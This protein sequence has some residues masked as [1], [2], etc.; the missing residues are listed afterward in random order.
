MSRQHP[1]FISAAS[2]FCPRCCLSPLHPSADRRV[3]PPH[4]SDWSLSLSPPLRVPAAS[5]ACPRRLRRLIV[6]D[7]IHRARPETRVHHITAA[8]LS[9]APAASVVCISII[10][11]LSPQSLVPSASV[12]YP[13]LMGPIGRLS[14]PP[15]SLVRVPA[16]S[17]ACPR[18]IRRMYP[19]HDDPHPLARIW[20]AFVA[21]AHST[22][23]LYPSHEHPL[24]V[25]SLSGPQFG[26][27]S[28]CPGQGSAVRSL[29]GAGRSIGDR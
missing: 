10:R 27:Q 23:R 14:P 17:V 19:L 21:R 6:V 26:S 3:S 12:P 7:S 24:L 2:V 9:L 29:S 18:C 15:P 5:V 8:H 13:Q 11:L 25:P 4:W 16:A 22:R 28:V 20:H 1:S